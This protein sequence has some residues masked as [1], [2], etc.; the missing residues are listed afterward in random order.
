VQRNKDLVPNEEQESR[1]LL[2]K[3]FLEKGIKVHTEMTA[4]S[5]SD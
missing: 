3:I 1:D 5:A 2:K 4:T